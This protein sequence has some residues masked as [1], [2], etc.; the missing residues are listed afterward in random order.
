MEDKKPKSYKRF[1]FVFTIIVILFSVCYIA[2]KTGYY[3]K[4]NAKETILTKD[5]ILAFEK[6]VAS[7]KPVD[8]KDYIKNDN[9]D[10]QNKYSKIGFTLSKVIETILTDGTSWVFNFLKSLFT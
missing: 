10:Y 5:A 7:G 9:L 6:D 4:T 3:E 2:S 1:K 8:I